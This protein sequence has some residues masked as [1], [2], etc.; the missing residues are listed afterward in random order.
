[1]E[2]VRTRTAD[3]IAHLENLLKKS[4]RSAL[5]RSRSEAVQCSVRMFSFLM[6]PLKLQSDRH[7]TTEIETAP[8]LT[9]ADG[10]IWTEET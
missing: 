2:S 3:S 1:M 6:K 7:L 4:P 8:T 5:E 10:N 9:T